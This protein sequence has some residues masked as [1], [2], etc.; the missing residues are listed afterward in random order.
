M[1]ASGDYGRYYCFDHGVDPENRMEA[2]RHLVGV[3]GATPE[4][5]IK[6][7]DQ[8]DEEYEKMDGYED[9]IL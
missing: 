6:K 9:E 7:L 8:I 5:A 3:H 2:A 4:Q 1:R